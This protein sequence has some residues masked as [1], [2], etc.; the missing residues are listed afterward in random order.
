MDRRGSMGSGQG[1]GLPSML[2][3]P[4][5]WDVTSVTHQDLLV[6]PVCVSMAHKDA[7]SNDSQC[8]VGYTSQAKHVPSLPGGQLTKQAALPCNKTLQA[9]AS[10]SFVSHTTR[11]AASC[12]PHQQ[13]AHGLTYI[14]NQVYC[15]ALC[16]ARHQPALAVE[17]QPIS[18][19]F[20]LLR[21]SL[22]NTA[23][24]VI[25]SLIL[26]SCRPKAL[27]L[28]P[29]TM[30]VCA[31][32]AI[33]GGGGRAIF[34]LPTAHTTLCPTLEGLGQGYVEEICQDQDH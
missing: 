30:I 6:Q 28:L 17:A 29:H 14:A 33:D 5:A 4:S 25:G 11:S 12:N 7:M 18:H 21:S 23:L 20:I 22:A 1:R 24:Q 9:F 3:M 2:V 26:A 8:Q 15:H 19:R 34:P 10:S 32:C 27:H 13:L 16:K 31:K